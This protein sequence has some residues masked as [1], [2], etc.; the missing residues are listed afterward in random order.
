MVVAAILGVMN[1][2]PV[3]NEVPPVSESYQFIVPAEAT[4]P[5]VTEPESQRFAGVVEVIVGG[6]LTVAVIA[7]LVAV[8]HPDVVAST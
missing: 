4:A 5:N 1:E 3:P 7:V 8:V 6:K 2:F